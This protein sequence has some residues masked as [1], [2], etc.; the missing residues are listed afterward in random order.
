VYTRVSWAKDDPDRTDNNKT[1]IDLNMAEPGYLM[2]YAGTNVQHWDAAF[3]QTPT[4]WIKTV[5]R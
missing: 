5:P 1:N 3:N 4:M 2:I